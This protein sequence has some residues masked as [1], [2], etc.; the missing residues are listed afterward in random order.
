[1][2]ILILLLLFGVGW[3][4]ILNLGRS[5]VKY[6]CAYCQPEQVHISF[7]GESVIHDFIQ[8]ILV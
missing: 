8:L 3:G 7:G 4:K 5:G 1:M 6:D 2:K